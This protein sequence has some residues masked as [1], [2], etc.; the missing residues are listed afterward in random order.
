MSTTAQLDYRAFTKTPTQASLLRLIVRLHQT[1]RIE[2]GGTPYLAIQLDRLAEMVGVK[3]KSSVSRA[4]AWLRENGL[5]QIVR[6]RWNRSPRLYLRPLIRPRRATSTQRETPL[7]GCADATCSHNPLKETE[8][9]QTGASRADALDAPATP[10]KAESA[11]MPLRG[12]L[13]DAKTRMQAKVEVARARAGERDA[14]PTAVAH[15][16]VRLLGQ[17][18]YPAFP[19]NDKHK[20]HVRRFIEKIGPKTVAECLKEIER[21]IGLWQ[22]SR[23]DLLKKTPPHPWALLR[24]MPIFEPKE[25][26][27]EPA[28]T[29]PKEPL[30]SPPQ[31][32]SVDEAMNSS[33]AAPAVVSPKP[34]GIMYIK[35]AKKDAT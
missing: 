21:R 33:V 20:A 7:T 6:D 30:A 15:G 1:S 5:I 14:V 11:A 18:G 8:T 17:Y 22:N 10:E 4:L 34:P 31:Q 3:A 32:V 2:R 26:S 19:L 12:P 24:T 9:S 25:D 16:W 13:E 23:P 28:F 29:L 35:P 27:G